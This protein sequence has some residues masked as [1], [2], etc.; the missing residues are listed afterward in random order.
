MIWMKQI[1][2]FLFCNILD[3]HEPAYLIRGPIFIY[4]VFKHCYRMYKE[5]DTTIKLI[6]KNRLDFDK[7]YLHKK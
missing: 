1:K 2:R 4:G 3:R 7:N 5:D 6:N